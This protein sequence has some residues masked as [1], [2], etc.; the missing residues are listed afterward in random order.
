MSV[1]HDVLFE[2]NDSATMPIE[3]KSVEF[4]LQDFKCIYLAIEQVI[5]MDMC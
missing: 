1:Y 3:N 4:D 5:V 2:D